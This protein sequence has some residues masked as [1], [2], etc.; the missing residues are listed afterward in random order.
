MRIL[1]FADFHLG[2][3]THGKLDSQTGLNTREVQAL[4][5]LD[6]L[7]GYAINN[8]IK[9][10]IAAGDMY[11]NNLP[12]P[13]LQDEFNKRIK[14]AANNG[15]LVLILDGNH[16]VGKT[17]NSKSAMASFETLD[18]DNVICTKYH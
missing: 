17:K 10:I 1:T 18:V 9:V 3:K 15:I 7:I 2:T 12:T 4:K 11:K 8:D 16:D 14:Y 6:E 5:S 13:T